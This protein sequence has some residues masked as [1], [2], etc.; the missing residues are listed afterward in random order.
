MEL[1]GFSMY[2]MSSADSNSFTLFFPVWI[3]YLFLLCLLCLELPVQYWIKNSESAHLYF[4]YDL[5]R[6]ASNFSLLSMVLTVDLSYML[7]IM[8]RYIH[9][10]LCWEVFFFLN[11][12]WMLDFIKSFF[13][14]CWDDNMISSVCYC[15]FMDIEKPSLIS[16]VNPIW[17]WCMI[18]LMYCW[19]RFAC[20]LLRIFASMFIS[21]IGLLLYSGLILVTGW[22]WEGR[23]F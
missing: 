10:P 21:G 13:C 20:V 16:E 19:I 23:H 12:K 3:S 14:I 7:F 9:S 1:L 22:W 15:V 2:N 8:L 18:F 11:H 6:K 4:L 17:L 5:R